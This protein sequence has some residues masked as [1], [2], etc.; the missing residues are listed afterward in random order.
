[1]QIQFGRI[2]WRLVGW[3]TLILGLILALLG[4]SIYVALSRSLVAEVDR[5]LLAQSEQAIGIL[6]PP[7]RR[8]DE[9]GGGPGG[10]GKKY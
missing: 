4:T 1:V 9:P 8:G 5:T 3:N 7:P 10:G 6:F 2:R